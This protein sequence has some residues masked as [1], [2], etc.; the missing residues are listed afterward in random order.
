MST[1]GDPGSGP[2]TSGDDPNV[3]VEA[4]QR[5]RGAAFSSGLSV[6]DFAAC[7]HLG[8]EPVGFVQGFCV[9]GWSWPYNSPWRDGSGNDP[10]LSSYACNHYNVDAL[11]RVRG[12][13]REFVPYGQAWRNA[14]QAAR[15]RMLDE[16]HEAGADGVIDVS[17][18]ISRMIDS[19]ILEFHLTGTAVR[20]AGSSGSE[21]IWSTYV[22]A[23]PLTKLLEAGFMPVS[24][25]ATVEAVRVYDYCQ[26]EIL[27]RG[28]GWNYTGTAEIRQLSDAHMATRRLARA[29]IRDQLGR[30][31]LHGAEMQVGEVELAEGYHEIVCTLRG[32]RVRQFEAAEPLPPPLP[33]VSLA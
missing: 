22:A 16:A 6:S 26:T 12:D 30:D 27:L 21:H 28:G 25:V 7:L 19:S 10:V 18:R 14:Y 17:E 2:P 23:Q 3:P 20:L 5:L 9:T 31:T 24:V 4:G 32:T 11:H 33:T 13:N 8:L 29:R 15:Q 1:D